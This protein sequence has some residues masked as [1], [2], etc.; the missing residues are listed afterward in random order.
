MRRID[1][2]ALKESQKTLYSMAFLKSMSTNCSAKN[3][4]VKTIWATL[5]YHQTYTQFNVSL[6]YTP[7]CN[8][9]AIRRDR[10]T[11]SLKFV[12]LW[13]CSFFFFFLMFSLVTIPTV[14]RLSRT[15]STT[16][17]QGDTE[18]PIFSMSRSNCSFFSL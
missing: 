12:H 4:Y 13:I 10:L 2:G 1:S 17:N 14:N 8:I 9:I 5:S 3:A 18:E 11:Y 15:C 7:T 16:S 6:K